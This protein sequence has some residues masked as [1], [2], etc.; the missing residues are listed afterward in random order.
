MVGWPEMGSEFIL[1]RA[2]AGSGKTYALSLRFARFLLTDGPPDVPRDLPHILA[3]T[4]TRNAAREMK[5][6]I[7][8][9]LKEGYRGE[10]KKA[11]TLRV[12]LHK[13]FHE[14]LFSPAE[15]SRRSEAAVERILAGYTDFQV[16][17]IDSFATMVFRASAVDL[18]Y[19]PD[20]EISLDPGELVDYAFARFLRRV[21]PESAEGEVFRRI[22]DYLLVQ[23]SEKARFLWDPAPKILQRLKAFQKK[24][25]A[26][27]GELVLDD[28]QEEKAKLGEKIRGTAGRL[29][30][31]V[32]ESGL[33]LAGRSH[34]RDR[35]MP[36]VE[37]GRFGDL[38]DCSFG[39]LPV[40]GGGKA[41]GAAAEALA[42]IEKE[43]KTLE[44]L[45]GEYARLHARD[46]FLPYL[47]A[48]Q[49][50]QAEMKGAK[51]G[52]GLLFL[53]DVNRELLHYL[54]RGIV[55]DVYFRLGDRIYHYLIDEFQDTSPIQWRILKPL[56]EESLSR[57]GSLLIVGDAKQA[58][59]GFRDADFR[60]M[61]D[62][63]EGADGFASAP[64]FSDDLKMNY[65]SEGVILEFVKDVFLGLASAPGG[66]GEKNGVDYGRLAG[67]SG[68]NQF[69]QSVLPEREGRGY[70][71]YVLFDKGG[72][73]AETGEG[74]EENAGVPG[75]DSE[76]PEKSEIQALIKELLGRGWRRADLAV[77][78][79]RNNEVAAVASWLN[80]IDIPFVSYSS[81]DIRR[82]K[83]IGEILSFLR[84]LDSPP[85]DLA[86][87]EFLLGDLFTKVAGK[88]FD[89][90]ARREFLRSCARG[91]GG[92]RYAALRRARPA[93]WE[94]YFEPF[95]KSVGYLPLY[96]LVTRMYREFD[97]FQRFP[98]EEAALSKLLEA[99]K[100]FEGEGRNDLRE[101]LAF[102]ADEEDSDENWTIDVPRETD[103]VKIMSIHKAKGATIPVVICLFYGQIFKGEEFYL[104]DE[105]DGV[106]VLK[107]NK[108][109]A[110]S[111]ASLGAAYGEA[112][113]R[114]WV[115]RL[116]TLYVA[117]TRA[118]YELYVV[119]VKGKKGK[120]PF[121]LLERAFPSSTEEPVALA[122]GAR[123]SR[124]FREGGPAG[125]E[126][127]LR[128]KGRDEE[129]GESGLLREITHR[130][131][132]TEPPEN[133]RAS[134]KSAGVRRGEW[135]H[136]LLAGIELNRAG[137][138]AE[139]AAAWEGLG[140]TSAERTAAGEAAE[141][142][143]R[144][145]G[146]SIAADWFE[147]RPDRFVLREAA[148]CD[149]EGDV[150]R[151]DRVVL[152][153][154][155]VMVID[156]KTGG[157]TEEAEAYREQIRRYVR[158]LKDV[159]P[160]RP[161][162]GFLS[163]VDRDRIEEVQ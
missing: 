65:R 149:P 98:G 70:V 10:G 104:H 40:K 142:L 3:I 102:S 135:I 44:G 55:P 160:G 24:L 66:E 63:E 38:L 143:R 124:S 103:A 83:I 139:V 34:Y 59:Y 119:G 48:Y 136:R 53:D 78:A 39:T 112:R 71:R 47:R 17:T 56:I 79:G 76:A 138:D 4:F 137:W 92:P 19:G 25:T 128:A 81:L 97:V 18:G 145:Y 105:E 110:E 140:L 31:A 28:F 64:A 11:E 77:L 144:A 35:I 101:F 90:P 37:D 151:M 150:F 1:T 72:A 152:D 41:K 107:I 84:F 126:A 20:F 86:F 162:R 9:W 36:A 75:G 13:E 96:D 91:D 118:Q 141:V 46:F 16:D 113:D 95:F 67:L 133:R 109:L 82:R 29:R 108:K 154:G 54:E 100:T 161:V 14:R 7:L 73:A 27:P 153:P 32:E 127:Y 61:R 6:R 131:G 52:R 93:L 134:M 57:G 147:P 50:V 60:I 74:E 88:E 51:L 8:D 155:S 157:R 12:K 85:D 5:E 123:L 62:L 148:I 163:F 49:S 87:A 132:F 115:D 94:T 125:P 106:H 68:L 122:D 45:V 156:F 69:T 15:L 99:I 114:E 159:H 43:W 121:D 33:D 111:E 30:G 22:L 89:L 146:K 120:Y 117:L 116:N 23:E 26:R 129:S 2:S 158:L 58:I 130:A 80:E 21:K 42:R